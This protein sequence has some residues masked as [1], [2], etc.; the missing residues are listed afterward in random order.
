[1]IAIA[2]ALAMIYMV[3]AGQFERFLD[4]LVVMFS[5]PVALVGVIPVMLLTGTSLNIQ[6]VMGIVMLVGDDRRQRAVHV[7]DNLPLLGVGASRMVFHA[8]S[9]LL[10]RRLLR[11]P[12]FFLAVGAQA[13]VGGAASAPVVAAAFHPAFATVGALLAVL[14]YV[15]DTYVGILDAFV[16]QQIA[17]F[18]GG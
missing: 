4:P 16:L 15:L 9:M 11:A 6:S 12:V 10:V 7:A 18:Y 17:Q 13:N 1:M 5:V 2:L 8:A 14:G 3:M